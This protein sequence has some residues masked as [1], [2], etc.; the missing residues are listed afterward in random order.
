MGKNLS[1]CVNFLINISLR[2]SSLKPHKEVCWLSPSATMKLFYGLLHLFFGKA[3]EL[4]F[5]N[6]MLEGEPP[7]HIFKFVWNN[8]APK[9]CSA[10]DKQNTY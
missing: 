3:E 8:V 9:I 10:K 4:V 2:F 6:Y 7:A 5:I 1:I